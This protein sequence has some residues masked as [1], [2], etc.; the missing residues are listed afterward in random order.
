[1]SE[2]QVKGHKGQGQRSQGSRLHGSRSLDKKS[3]VKISYLGIEVISSS[4]DLIPDLTSTLLVLLYRYA[5]VRPL[6]VI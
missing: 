2:I 4:T 1:M 5:D 6:V 3:P